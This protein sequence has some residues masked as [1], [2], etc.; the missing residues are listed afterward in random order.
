[1]D[2]KEAK[3]LLISGMVANSALGRPDAVSLDSRAEEILRRVWDLREERD[4]KDESRGRR[5]S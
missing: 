5:V 1:M 4:S 3:V 2:R